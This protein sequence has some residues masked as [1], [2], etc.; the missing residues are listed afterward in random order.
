MHLG[1]QFRL[2]NLRCTL[3][4]PNS[5]KN[6]HLYKDNKSPFCVQYCSLLRKPSDVVRSCYRKAKASMAPLDHLIP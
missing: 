3:Y 6:D 5:G 1:H 2:Y 4:L